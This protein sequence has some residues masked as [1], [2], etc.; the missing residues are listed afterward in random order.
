MREIKFRSAH[1][2]YQDRFVKFTYWGFI[3]HK[4]ESSTD[5][6]TSPG[7]ISGTQRKYEEQYT[8]L[9][10]KNGTKIFEG[11][12]LSLDN[13]YDRWIIEYSGCGFKGVPSGNNNLGKGYLL[14]NN[15]Y[16]QFN[17]IGNIHEHK[18]LTMTTNEI[19]VVDPET[20]KPENDCSLICRANCKI[21]KDL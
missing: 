21:C 12:I 19:E 16:L 7:S 18:H 10:D 14:N 4:G 8:G 20:V 11:D 5:C 17:V 9:K 15:N 1:Y 13:G 6:F 3:N 2:D